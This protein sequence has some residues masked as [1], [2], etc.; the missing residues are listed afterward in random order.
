MDKP[1]LLFPIF[2]AGAGGSGQGPGLS[3]Y[4]FGEMTGTENVNCH[5]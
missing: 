1:R 3:Y 2:E 4:N 5:H